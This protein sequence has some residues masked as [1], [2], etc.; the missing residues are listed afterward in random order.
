MQRIT[1]ES[2]I[3]EVM[4]DIGVG[5]GEELRESEKRRKNLEKFAKIRSRNPNTVVSLEDTHT[6]FVEA[7]KTD[8]GEEFLDI[9][10]TTRQ[11]AQQTYTLPAA[12]H[13]YIIQKAMVIHEAAHIM[14]SDYQALAKY[15]DKVD[16]DLQDIFHNI[17]NILEDGAI[18]KFAQEDYRVD[19]ELFHLRSTI[20]EDNYM[21]RE[22]DM[23]DGA[24][25]HY[26]MVYAISTALLNI[27]V[28]DNGELRKLLDEDNDKH[29]MAIAGG[30]FDRKMFLEVLPKCRDG[31]NEIQDERDAEKRTELIYELWQELKKYINRS[32]TPGKSEM[33]REQKSRSSDSYQ[34]GVPANINEDHGKQQKSSNSHG[35]SDENAGQEDTL[36]EKRNEMAEEIQEIAEEVEQKAKEDVV[37]E[38]KDQSG[39]WSDELEEIVNSL[40]AGDG[41]DEIFIPDD[42][43]VDISQKREAQKHGKRCAKIFRTRLKRLQKDKTVTGKRR[44]SFDSR[45]IVQADRGSPRVFQRTKEGDKKNY[46][47]VVVCDRSGSMSGRINDVELAMG[48]VAYGLESVGVDV[49]IM[50]TYNS[51]TSLAKPFGSSVENFEEKLFANRIGGGTPL[52]YTLQFARQRIE[53]GDGDVPF[54]V[55]ITDGRPQNKH[56][57]K[58]QIKKANFPVIGLYLNNTKK[59]EQLKLYDRAVTVPRG[60]SVSQK[61]IN[62]IQSIMF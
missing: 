26:P 52:R 14:Y 28:Y 31:V 45:R 34:E 4:R 3:E 1:S 60:D 57:V 62:L 15:T 36:G 16:E 23:G 49:S 58:E 7:E 11:F 37:Q 48:S 33:E 54:M 2:Q 41:V 40:G 24:E 51:K 17:Y 6:A 56:K 53:R 42:G 46:S 30:E 43:D 12:Y 39:D 32:T 25:Y 22:V 5:A 59:Q 10:V 50:D 38:T 19:E 21:G 18:E 9:T 44:G 27:G 29:K 13:N 61:L 8:N 47:C 20:H 55:V 35:D